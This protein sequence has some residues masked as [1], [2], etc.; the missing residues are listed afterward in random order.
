M[1]LTFGD[2]RSKDKEGK[3]DKLSEHRFMY[4]ERLF[5]P[6]KIKRLS[7]GVDRVRPIPW[8][9]PVFYFQQPTK[10]EIEEARKRGVL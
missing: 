3:A 1:Y 7:F 4:I 9:A 8:D 10:E 6:S 5:G 2:H